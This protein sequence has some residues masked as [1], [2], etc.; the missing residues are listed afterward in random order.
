MILLKGLNVDLGE[1]R[2]RDV[3]LEIAGGEFFALMGPTG[4]GKT[5]LLEAIAGLVPVLS[6]AIE[7]GGRDITA[8]PPEKRGVGI[9]YQDYSLFPHLSVRQNILYGARYCHS[10]RQ[11]TESLLESLSADLCIEGI[12]H[13]DPKTL[14]GGEM[15]RVT[16]ARALIVKPDIL[17]LDEPLSAIDA[18]FRNDLRQML[19]KLHRDTG[20][21][22]L[23]VTHDFA[24]ALT[25]AERA[26]VINEGR[27]EQVGGVR[28]IFQRPRSSFVASFVGMK[29]ILPASFNGDTA[30]VNG[31]SITVGSVHDR[32]QGYITIRPEDIVLSRSPLDSSMRNSF[33]GIVSEIV[34]LGFSCEV[35]L[36]A[37]DTVFIALVTKGALIDLDITEGGEFY[38][39]FKATAVHCF[40]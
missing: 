34:D 5:V 10:S 31:L 29:N 30:R 18:V 15:Q 2:L 23:M 39:S 13:R 25:L 14:S 17:L 27:I 33:R 3:D 4:A 6:G 8:L 35:Y 9:V 37:G 7:A 1:F 38:L 32:E 11:D 16:L 12:L 19:K 28:D 22:F 40:N 21:T 24:E 36:A 20:A 26:A